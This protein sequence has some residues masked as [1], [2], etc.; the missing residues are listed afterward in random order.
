VVVNPCGEEFFPKI[1]TVPIL[2]THNEHGVIEAEIYVTEDKLDRIKVTLPTVTIDVT[3]KD[4]IVTHSKDFS[5]GTQGDHPRLMT[6][7]NT[8]LPSIDY[9]WGFT[10]KLR[11]GEDTFVY[12]NN[13]NLLYFKF[14]YGNITTNPYFKDG[15]TPSKLV[16]YNRLVTLIGRTQ[17]DDY[18]LDI[19]ELYPDEANLPIY[20]VLGAATRLLFICDKDFNPLK[21]YSFKDI[22]LSEHIHLYIEPHR[23]RLMEIH[24]SHHTLQKFES[25]EKE[26][27]PFIKRC[28]E[29]KKN[30]H[31]YYSLLKSFYP[32]FIQG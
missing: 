7:D 13:E 26:V 5:I 23:V 25:D 11:Y 9:G 28:M 24:M 10:F 30:Y 22:K 4:F 8:Y 14:S 1:D 16:S 31:S 6:S 18:Y 2:L 27:I 21:V 19:S 17:C 15:V 32:P 3:V 12:D 20:L 29:L